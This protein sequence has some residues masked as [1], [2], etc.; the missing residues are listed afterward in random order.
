[1]STNPPGSSA[2]GDLRVLDLTSFVAGPYCT[3]LLA[4]FGAKVIKVEPPA[5][6]VARRYGPFLNDEPHPEGSLLFLYLNSNKS[7][8]TLNLD[9][10]FGQGVV[11]QLAALCDVVVEDFRPGTLNNA[12]IGYEALASINSK[13]VMVSIT[14]FGQDGPYKD[15]LGAEIVEFALGGFMYTYGEFDREPVKHGG[16]QVQYN[17][18]ANAASAGL[19][20]LRHQRISGEGQHV[21]ISAI[22]CQASMLRDTTS[23]YTYMGAIRRRAVKVANRDGRGST[24][25]G[26]GSFTAAK[27]GYFVGGQEGIPRRALT[28][29]EWTDFVNFLGMEELRQFDTEQKRQEH[30]AEVRNLLVKAYGQK[31]KYELVEA[32]QSHHLMFGPV[33]TI[34][35]LTTN[36]QLAAREYFVP[37]DHPHIGHVM[38]PGAP[39]RLTATPWALRSTAPALG[40]NNRDVYVDLLGYSPEDLIRLKGQGTI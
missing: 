35:D 6:D 40:A 32:A 38:F 5:G 34:A 27:D 7:S 26:Q 28:D 2:L 25:E 23:L 11:K 1:M 8:I 24:S 17:A 13:L 19:V 18:G 39:F 20:A 9:T 14:P 31:D 10:A 29:E 21:D 30:A 22:E 3:K 33:E 36:P 15:Y 12:G 4:D 16:H 37:I